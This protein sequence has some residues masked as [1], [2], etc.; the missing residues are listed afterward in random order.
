MLAMTKSAMPTPRRMSRVV[1]VC[2]VC[3]RSAHHCGESGAPKPGVPMM[4]SVAAAASGGRVATRTA[5]P[6]NS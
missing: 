6:K 4:L 5:R 1:P 3:S 2:G